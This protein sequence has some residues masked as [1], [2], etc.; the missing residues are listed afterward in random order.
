MRRASS[1]LSPNKSMEIDSF[2][3]SMD[4]GRQSEEARVFALSDT[5][6]V[7]LAASLPIEVQQVFQAAGELER[8]VAMHPLTL[9]QWR[10]QQ[11]HIF[12]LSARLPWTNKLCRCSLGAD[13]LCLEN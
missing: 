11:R 6:S 8:H 10:S 4:R 12:W 2:K 1:G 9:R 7:R 13:M 5:L 3:L